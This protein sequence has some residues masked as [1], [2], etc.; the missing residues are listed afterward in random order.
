MAAAS[1]VQVAVLAAAARPLVA[2]LVLLW[3]ARLASPSIALTLAAAVAMFTAP[4][5]LEAAGPAALA[6]SSPLELLG[7]EL[8]RGATLGLFA[9]APLWAAAVAGRWA[10]RA[11]EDAW[12]ASGPSPMRTLYAAMT[13]V[14]FLA[15]QG[16]QLFCAALAR[17]YQAAPLGAA[18]AGPGSLAL[19]VAQWAKAAVML[20]LPVLLA[21]AVAQLSV[22]AATRAAA[23]TAVAFPRAV[24]APVVVLLMTA[25]LGPS[26][27]AALAELLRQGLAS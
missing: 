1:L 24:V 25:A 5:A 16:P 26:L 4:A 3:A 9:A 17:S 11:L 23:A 6:L 13:G 22:A 27:C 19:A 18:L 12:P 21:A 20:S 7:R 14:A 8:V 10:G 15:V 2:V